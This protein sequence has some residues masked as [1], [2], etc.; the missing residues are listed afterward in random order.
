L[1][2]MQLV[3][4]F[5]GAP[6]PPDPDMVAAA[7][8]RM[9]AGGPA[10]RHRFA[11]LP[12]APWPGEVTRGRGRRL[13]GWLAPLA[14]AA[15]MTV[16]VAVLVV[17][18]GA[19]GGTGSALA[20]AAGRPDI[21][22]TVTARYLQPLQASSGHRTP[23][24]SVYDITVGTAT[25]RDASTG[26]VLTSVQ[27]WPR[28]QEHPRGPAVSLPF[29]QVA[30]AAAADDRTFAISDQGGF[31][32]LH[33]AASGRAARLNRL[34]ITFPGGYTPIDFDLSPDGTKLAAAVSCL[35]KG[36]C[37]DGISIITLATG[38]AR[39]WLAPSDADQ[40]MSPSWTDNGKAVMFQWSTGHG[41]VWGYRLLS[42]AAP[43]GNLTAESEPLRY[44][45]AQP[46]TYP[47]QWVETPA[48]LTPDGRSLLVVTQKVVPD[49]R[50]SGTI[51]FRITDEAPRTGRLLRVLRVFQTHYQGNPYLSKTACNILSL[52][53]GG[54]HALVECPQFG[55]LDGSTFTPLPAGPPGLPN[56]PPIGVA[57]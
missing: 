23:I 39:T 7:K 49:S 45:P 11:G 36:V 26:A 57:W 56:A 24:V 4:D 19:P 12:Q 35:S 1:D 51:I 2:E 16:V 5:F 10:V 46:G 22:V 3:R 18:R 53:P 41:A 48:I 55:R 32:L 47:T 54:L 13:A 34:N 37:I 21:Y 43:P 15:A 30:I 50:N 40:A 29:M 14:A 27:L 8:A 20:P 33:V 6:P 28:Q 44:P 17:A 42:D 31:Y 25:I 38:T 9:S 52:A